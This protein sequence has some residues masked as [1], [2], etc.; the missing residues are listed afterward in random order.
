[1]GQFLPCQ[2]IP[3]PYCLKQRLSI[4]LLYF[5]KQ[6]FLSPKKPYTQTLRKIPAAYL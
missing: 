2:L 5:L 3:F 6:T 1:M 4:A